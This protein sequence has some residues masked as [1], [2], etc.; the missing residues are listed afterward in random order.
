MKNPYE[1]LGVDKNA[2]KNE[3]K[4]TYRKKAKQYHPDLNPGNEEAAE[5]FKELSQ[6]YEILADDEKRKMYDTYGEAAFENGGMGSGAGADGFG[7]FNINMDDIFGDIFSDLFTGSGGRSNPDAP[8]KGADMRIQLRLKFKEA[9]FGTKKKITYKKEKD[10]SHCH[11]TG[12][13][14]GAKPE[15]CPTCHGTGTV[16]REVNSPFGR[17]I[18][19]TTCPTCHGTGSVIKEMCDYC[20][21]SGRETVKETINI[22]IPAGVDDGNILPLRGAGHAGTK[23]G[24]SGDLYVIIRVE[25]SQFFQRHGNDLSF[26]MP[27]SFVQAA[28][29]DVVKV[30]TLE[31]SRDFTIPE[32][33]QSGTR[34]TL[35]GEGVKN[36]KSGRKGN[37]Y[38]TVNVETPRNLN[39]EQKEALKKFGDAM[40]EKT[41]E[42]KKNFFEKV[43]DLFD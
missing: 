7:G 19:R 27:I 39:S 5:K 34:F 3:I 40:G 15:I 4:K 20:H 25:P 36:V 28:L 26:E 42:T 13:K 37:L 31:G 23:G 2:D 21:G 17:M 11:G 16:S 43:R 14:D 24:P 12:A 8:R 10:C 33:T 41:E 35:K 32:G 9:V 38:F 18:N 22:D 30:P 29:G 6:A 1:V